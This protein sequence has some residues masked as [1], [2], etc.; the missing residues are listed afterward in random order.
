MDPKTFRYSDLDL[1][2]PGVRSK[3]RNLESDLKFAFVDAKTKSLFLPFESWRHPLRQKW[4]LEVKK[5]TKADAFQSP[6]QYGMAVDFVAY[7]QEENRWSW[8]ANEDWEFLKERAMAHGLLRPL[9]W[10]L[11]HIE[12]PRWHD[13]QLAVK[14]TQKASKAKIAETEKIFRE[15]GIG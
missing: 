10:D 5:T 4:L 13:V 6:H 8:D 9:G 1:L 12:D 14:I 3:F 7:H 2:H 15:H 11:V